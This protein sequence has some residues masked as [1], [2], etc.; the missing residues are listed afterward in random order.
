MNTP[1]MSLER[2]HLIVGDLRDAREFADYI[3]T[4]RLHEKHGQTKELI[5][6]A[7]NLSMIISYSRPFMRNLEGPER[8]YDYSPISYL[9]KFVL[10][11]E[12]S[13]LHKTIIAQRNEIHAHSPTGRRFPRPPTKDRV[14]ISIDVF[15]PLS[16][17]DTRTLRSNIKSWL[18][19]LEPLKSQFS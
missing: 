17:A 16:L 18:D 7:F 6:R 15:M 1:E 19:Y 11:K 12:G 3:L 5:H 10:G 8:E 4:R 2:F 13:T 9:A 14:A